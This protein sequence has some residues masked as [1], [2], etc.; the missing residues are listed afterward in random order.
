MSV[1]GA[2]CK[3]GV[4]PVKPRR[5]PLACRCG[6]TE[7]LEP[8]IEPAQVRFI[9]LQVRVAVWRRVQRCHAVTA[10]RPTGQGDHFQ[11][12]PFGRVA[13]HCHIDGEFE[14]RL[15]HTGEAADLWPQGLEPGEVVR[16]GLILNDCA[17]ALG[18]A[19]LM[20]LGPS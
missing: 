3:A 11:L 7:D 19:H 15:F 1:S 10:K 2:L 5:H 4:Q 14:R 9:G 12:C 16:V 8:G 20:H 18:K 17:D 13:A 6:K